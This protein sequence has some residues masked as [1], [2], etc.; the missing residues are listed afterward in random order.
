MILSR[1]FNN[2]D[3]LGMVNGVLGLGGIIGGVIVSVKKINLDSKKMIYYSAAISFLL[4]DLFMAER[5]E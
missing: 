3:V 1:S 4:G 5:K 2:Y